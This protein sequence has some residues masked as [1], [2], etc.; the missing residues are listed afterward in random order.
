MA[1][2]T[3]QAL[4]ERAL[5]G[6][7]SHVDILSNYGLFLAEVKQDFPKAKDMYERALVIDPSH[8]NCLYN[9]AVM[10]DGGMK[11]RLKGKKDSF[12]LATLDEQGKVWE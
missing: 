11:V 4:Y 3:M 7:P 6:D 12:L 1:C 2:D 8:G 9:Y 10:L 5:A